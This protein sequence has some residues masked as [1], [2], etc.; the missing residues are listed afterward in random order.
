VTVKRF[1]GNM[2]KLGDLYW[3]GYHDMYGKLNDLKSYLA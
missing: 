2:D 3:L 1:E